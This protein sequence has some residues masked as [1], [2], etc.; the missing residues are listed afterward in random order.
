MI[1]LSSSLCK[2]SL[3]KINISLAFYR[4]YLWPPKELFFPLS[5]PCDLWNVLTLLHSLCKVETQGFFVFDRII[6]S[7]P[8]S[9]DF[10]CAT[11]DRR[12]FHQH[13]AGSMI[14]LFQVLKLGLIFRAFL[15]ISHFYFEESS[16]ELFFQTVEDFSDWFLF[17]VQHSLT[18]SFWVS[19]YAQMW[20]SRWIDFFSSVGL[21]QKF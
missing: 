12:K 6:Q 20:P 19:F 2:H 18:L 8:I 21:D 4:I 14:S 16:V 11:F 17:L 9:K 10:C 1:I 3:Q 13:I 7:D 5:F 15:E